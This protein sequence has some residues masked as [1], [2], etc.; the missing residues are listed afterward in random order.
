MG[1]AW[2]VDSPLYIFCFFPFNAR[3]YNYIN[4]FRNCCFIFLRDYGCSI[5]I[6]DLHIYLICYLIFHYMLIVALDD[7][8]SNHRYLHFLWIDCCFRS[9]EILSNIH[10]LVR[11]FFYCLLTILTCLVLPHNILMWQEVLYLISVPCYPILTC[12]SFCPIT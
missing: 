1:H 12:R 2:L 7:S 5:S 9:Y 11:C 4:P 10:F 8:Y 3:L 6:H